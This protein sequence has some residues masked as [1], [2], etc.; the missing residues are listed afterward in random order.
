M[1]LHTDL[2]KKR[3]SQVALPPQQGLQNNDTLSRTKL[4]L[5]PEAELQSQPHTD[6][7]KNKCL[8]FYATE[9]KVFLCCKG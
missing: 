4:N 1:C 3:M 6:K 8:S 7:Q 9:I 2:H 5:Q